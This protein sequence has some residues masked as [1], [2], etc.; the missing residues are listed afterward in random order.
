MSSFKSISIDTDGYTFI[1]CTF[2]TAFSALTLLTGRQEEHRACIKLSDE[3]LAWLSVCS[4]VEMICIW[5]S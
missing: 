2:H 3:V 1:D 4:E 5:S